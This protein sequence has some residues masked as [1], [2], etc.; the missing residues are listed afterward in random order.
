M[1]LENIRKKIDSI[2]TQLVELLKERME[3]AAEVAKYKSENGMR[4]YD[5]DRE[6]ALM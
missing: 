3:C 6:R 2:D 4:I 1:D 5:P